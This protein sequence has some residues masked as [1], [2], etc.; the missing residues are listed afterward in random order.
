MSTN[1]QYTIIAVDDEVEI[2]EVLQYQLSELKFKVF[3]FQRPEDALKKIHDNSSE[4]A[5]IISD[6][7]M[8]NMN[9]FQFRAE[10]L[11]IDKDIPFIIC[12]A[13]VSREDAL[14]ALE[15]KITSFISKPFKKEE[16]WDQVQKHTLDRV[17][18][19]NDDL[20]LKMGFIE[21][22]ENLLEDLESNL[23]ELQQEVSSQTLQKIFGIIHTIKGSSGFFK[24][25]I[26]NKFAHQFEDFYSPYA[27]GNKE[28]HNAVLNV[29]LKGYDQLKQLIAAFKNNSL[30]KYQLE[31]LVKLFK[32]DFETLKNETIEVSKTNLEKGAQNV[33]KDIKVSMELLDEFSELSG[34]VTVIRNMINKTLK[35]VEKEFAGNKDVNNLS[36]LL[37]EMYKINTSLQEKVELIRRYP[38]KDLFRPLQRTVRDLSQ[39]L[40]KKVEFKTENDQLRI[41]SSLYDVL[42]NSLIHLVR[43]SID[44]GLENEEQ[45]KASNKNPV[46]KVFISARETSDEVIVTI[47]DDGRGLNTEVLKNKILEK[48]LKTNDEIKKMSEKDIWSM[49]FASGFSTAQQITDVSGRGV[50]MDMVK[51][52]VEKV[53]GKIDIHS[54][55]NK[56]LTF[57]ITLPIPKTVMIVGSVI[58]HSGNA[59]YAIL[60]DNILRLVNY[61]KDDDNIQ[62]KH[63]EGADC[64][65]V[66]NKLM[67]IIHLT[68]ALSHQ[69]EK[70][71]CAK[72]C[73]EKSGQYVLVKAEGIEYAIYV[74]SI[75]DQEDTVIKKLG[76]HLKSV[77]HFL[78]AT[79]SGDGGVSLILDV[80][81]LAQIYGIKEDLHRINEEAKKENESQLHNQH[82]KNSF[83]ENYLLFRMNNPS[84][85]GIKLSEVFRLEKFEHSQIQLS[86][87]QKVILY[88]DGLLPLYDLSSYL[89]SAAMQSVDS[90]RLNAHLNV[91]V[92]ETD[93][94]YE[95]YIISSIEDL[96]QTEAILDETLGS[97]THLKGAMIIDN[98]T[99]SIVSLKNAHTLEKQS[100]LVQVINP[101]ESKAA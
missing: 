82:L 23:L 7:N 88:R 9:G 38:L 92:I 84:L 95:G 50:G 37:N 17:N 5:L 94:K 86:G 22:A 100:P 57:T 25:S 3:T 81:G 97:G 36:E 14:S 33:A 62:F 29:L 48:K 41:D 89:P 63:L 46:G 76:P 87:E 6:F 53:G 19:L 67:P 78:G 18:Q 4:V 16:V 24:N 90:D 77:K 35:K 79:Y 1:P 93:N 31:D 52:S 2:L 42:S 12:S 65:L 74:D 54:V 21:E 73:S 99:V 43:N 15:Y 59:Q 60:Q 80:T 68:N 34:E 58:V 66:D 96:V 101:K 98:K 27:K 71:D 28:L 11:K 32:G 45:R 56:G 75:L 10:V 40:K 64:L 30:H 13:H 47:K 85:F 20:N 55:L 39:T 26:I 69:K 70:R 61:E 91:I 51:K 49:I 8:P 72:L 44:H 83:L